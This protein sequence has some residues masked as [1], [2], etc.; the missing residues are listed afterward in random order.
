MDSVLFAHFA[1]YFACCC[2]MFPPK[3]PH[4]ADRASERLGLSGIHSQPQTATPEPLSFHER[5]RGE[6]LGETFLG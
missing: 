6:P 2:N 3:F 5:N 4:S 1:Q